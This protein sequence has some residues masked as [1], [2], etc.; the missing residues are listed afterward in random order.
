MTQAARAIAH[1]LQLSGMYGFDFVIDEVTKQAKLIEINPRATQINHMHWGPGADLPTALRCALEGQACAPGATITRYPAEIALF[2]QEW[3]RDRRS[4]YLAGAFHDVPFEEPE[5]LKFYGYAPADATSAVVAAATTIFSPSVLNRDAVC[6]PSAASTPAVDRDAPTSC[7]AVPLRA[8]NT[9][10]P[11]FLFPGVDCDVEEMRDLAERI[12]GD[13]AVLGLRIDFRTEAAA[14]LATVDQMAA[15]AL[16][17]IRTIQPNGP[18]HLAGYSFGGIVAFEAA[19]QIRQSGS[20]VKLLALIGAPISQ[21]YWPLLILLRSL[22]MRAARH[23]GVLAQQ[24]M[25]TAAPLLAARAAR[26]I[27][28]VAQRIV[29]RVSTQP[30]ARLGA[31]AQ[32]NLRGR[33]AMERYRPDFYPGTLT[34]LKAAHDRE[35]FCDF[36]GLWRAYAGDLDV[37]SFPGNHLGLVHDPKVLG[38]VAE[39]IE[40]RLGEGS[41]SS[42]HIPA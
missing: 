36:S 22:V 1:H 27:C 4:P 8:G 9:A 12:R 13:R 11:L 31:D 16:T 34:F 19:R 18:Y 26:L 35:F 14:P 3:L 39:F 24:P 29:P 30:L 32:T 17:E 33:V 6:P 25:G 21:R 23:L 28:M 37:R 10:A 40:L 2:P 41:Q 7:Q 20:E 5:F 15:Q 38:L 42:R